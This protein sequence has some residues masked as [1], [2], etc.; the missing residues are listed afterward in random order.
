MVRSEERTDQAE[1]DTA[2]AADAASAFLSI[3]SSQREMLFQQRLKSLL[4]DVM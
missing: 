1:N 4:L 3:S 2:D